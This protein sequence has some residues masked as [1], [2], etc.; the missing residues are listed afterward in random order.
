M[1]LGKIQDIPSCGDIDVG[2]GHIDGDRHL[3]YELDLVDGDRGGLPVGGR[4]EIDA[5]VRGVEWGF[6]IDDGHRTG[7]VGVYWDNRLRFLVFSTTGEE[8]GGSQERKE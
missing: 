5:D 7:V 3:G 4:G 6:L 8:D 1:I 2:D